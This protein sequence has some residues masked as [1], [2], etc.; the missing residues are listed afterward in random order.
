[1][2]NAF[3]QAIQPSIDQEIN[4]NAVD[5]AKPEKKNIIEKIFGKKDRDEKKR[6]KKDK[7]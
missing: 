2:Q 6:D 3:I 4:L 1:L 5:Q 7:K